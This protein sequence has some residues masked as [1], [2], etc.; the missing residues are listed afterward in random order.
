M[1]IRNLTKVKAAESQ[2]IDQILNL[3]IQIIFVLGALEDLLG[4][5]IQDSLGKGEEGA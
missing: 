5:S 3:I 4:F 1:H 2:S